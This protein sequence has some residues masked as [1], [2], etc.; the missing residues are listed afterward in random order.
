M[1]ARNKLY[2]AAAALLLALGML[3]RPAAQRPA[4]AES[5]AARSRPARATPTPSS[6]SRAP[7]PAK[8]F[9]SFAQL[10][11]KGEFPKLTRDQIESYLEAQHRSA[12]AL[13]AAF[14]LGR[15]D[16][17]LREAMEKFPHNPQVLLASLVWFT[18]E[19]AKRLEGLESLK[20]ADPDNG[21]A[22]GLA[23]RTLFDFGKND[24]ALAAL[25]QSV[26][27]PIRDYT[28][29]SSQ[30]A[31]EAYLSAG[32]SPLEAKMAAFFQGSK[33]AILDMRVVVEGLKKQRA[34]E[35]FAG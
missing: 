3:L 33:S 8:D 25:S 23:A 21:I 13:L 5:S 12:G 9:Q 11:V 30:N 19:P 28:V 6:S 32:F 2:I 35:V 10:A 24:E 1:S 17:F 31:E 27:K 14:H 4:D 18:R 7:R 29:L 20:R 22:D 26:G 15:D 16:A 34:S